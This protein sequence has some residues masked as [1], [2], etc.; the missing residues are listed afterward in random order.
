DTGAAVP[1]AGLAAVAGLSFS[2]LIAPTTTPRRIEHLVGLC[3][4]FVYLLARVGITGE[5][6][7][8][9]DVAGRVAAIRKLTDL[10]IAVGFGISR[11]EHVE[12][13]TACA[14]AAIV[15]SAL[16]RRMGEADNPVSAAGALVR[17]LAAGLAP[18]GTPR[19]S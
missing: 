6:D 15:G 4:G 11:P 12:A 13:V 3:S 18:A 5:R 8:A 1:V 7:D 19:G 14:E 9:P 17:R 10:P 16:V 2:V